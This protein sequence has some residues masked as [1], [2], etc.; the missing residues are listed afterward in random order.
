MEGPFVVVSAVFVRRQQGIGQC[1]RV[2]QAD[3]S[4]E[5]RRVSDASQRRGSM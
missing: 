5:K 2:T 4:K 1:G 3:G